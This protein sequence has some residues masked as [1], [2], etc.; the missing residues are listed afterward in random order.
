MFQHPSKPSQPVDMESVKN[1]LL[2]HKQSQKTY[3]DKAHGTCDLIELGP[4]QEMLIRSPVK[5]EYI[6]RTIVK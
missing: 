4:G 3:F 6:P 2:S 5:D 1:Y